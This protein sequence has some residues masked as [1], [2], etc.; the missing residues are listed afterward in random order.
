MRTPKEHHAL[1]ENLDTL[2]H[3]ADAWELPVNSSKCT[4][5]RLGRETPDI[6]YLMNNVPLRSTTTERKTQMN[7]GRACSAARSMLG[8]IRRSFDGL[9]FT[10]FKKFFASYVRSRLEYGGPSLYP[11]V[12][13]EMANL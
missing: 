6:P 2:H 12:L 13:S 5:M 1:Q 4:H 8:A 9:S 11:C 7:T 3:S 10:A